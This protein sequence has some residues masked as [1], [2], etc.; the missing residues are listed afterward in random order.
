MIRSTLQALSSFKLAVVLLILSMVLV[1]VGTWA[2]IDTGIY[3]VQKQYFHAW[4][5]W[6]D[7]GTILPRTAGGEMAIPGGLP[8]PGGYMIGL[9]LLIN[10]CANWVTRFPFVWR[11]SGIHL[12]HLGIVLLLVGEGWSSYAQIDSRMRLREG[13]SANFTS[14]YRHYEL[15][16]IDRSSGDF[17]RVQTIRLDRVTAGQT[18]SDPALPVQLKIERFAHNSQLFGPM[19]PGGS[20]DALAT[21]GAGVGVRMAEVRRASGTDNSVDAPS[22]FVTVLAGDRTI[23]TYLLSMWEPLDHPQPV[24]LGDGRMLE[25]QLRPKQYYKP[26]T[27]QLLD[28]RHDRYAGTGM[29]R[30]FSSRIRLIDPERGVDREELIWMNH[31]L[32]YRGDT[33]YQASFVGEDTT[34]FQVVRNPA[35][36]VPYIACTIG[37]LGLLIQLG[38]QLLAPRSSQTPSP[39]P[40]KPP[41]KAGWGRL[42]IPLG[43]MV[44]CG[45]AL[46]AW[47]IA[48]RAKPGEIAQLPVFYEGRLQPLDSVARNTLRILNGKASATDAEN[49]TITPVRWLLDVMTDPARAA[50]SPVVRIDNA[51]LLTSLNLDPQRKRFSLNQLQ[52]SSQTLLEQIAAAERTAPRDRDLVQ[53]QFLELRNRIER[54]LSLQEWPRLLLVPPAEAGGDWRSLDAA[55]GAEMAGGKVEP[56]A[57]HI[58]LSL[59]ARADGHTIETHPSTAQWLSTLQQE[60]P[61]EMS[62]MRLEIL[63]NRYQPFLVAMAIY[64]LIFL[65]SVVSMLIWQNALWR[66]AMAL[67]TVALALYTLAMLVRI[68]LQGRPPVTNLYSSAVFI[69]WG[70]ALTSLFVERRYRNGVALGASS[71]VAIASLI[72]AQNLAQSG[73]TMGSLQAVL[74]SNFWLSSHVLTITFGYAAVFVAGALAIGAVVGGV[75]NRRWLGE[76][77]GR[78]IPRMIYAVSCFALLFSFVGTILGGIW[79][80]QSWGRFWGWD[81]KENGAVLIVLWLAMM[82]HARFAGAQDRGMVAMAIGGN[83]VT[84][85][86]WFGTNM[87]GVGLHS[88][89]FMDSALLWLLIFVA[90]QLVLIGLSLLILPARFAAA[91]ERSED[92]AF[93]VAASD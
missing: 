86:S 19:Q 28:F 55:L 45:S 49:K 75:F 31:P 90:S 64:V 65:L 85:W 17:D 74:D 93:P 87:L 50:D 29:A 91:R 20:G 26:Y 13:E 81:P 15:A 10:L 88:Y 37:T 14:D 4:I 25:L 42:A 82:L 67:S 48:V 3:D 34:V 47:G 32:R 39:L 9:A 52:A 5:A 69:G 62:R 41:A 8:M 57:R 44:I 53:R 77:G 78:N 66:N 54:H 84:A 46:V 24:D 33:F 23:G 38:I 7:F 27:I 18:I 63:Y 12:I 11:K 60:H 21:V 22:A 58:A 76:G 35:V 51:D 68:I 73:D 40:V 59:A 2:Q 72:I 16:M 70:S 89:G 92:R 79:A 80:D 71:L 61:R 1:Y 43:L 36:A 83:I 6:V 56:L 30:N